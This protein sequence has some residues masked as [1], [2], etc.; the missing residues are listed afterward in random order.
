MKYAFILA[1]LLMYPLSVVCRVLS[2]TQSG[3]HAWRAKVQ[4][5]RVVAGV[6]LTHVPGFC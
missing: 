3:F 6:K 1:E 2:V 4:S 5:P